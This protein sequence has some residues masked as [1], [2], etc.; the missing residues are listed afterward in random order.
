MTAFML[1]EMAEGRLAADALLEMQRTEAGRAEKLKAAP[2]VL[3][4]SLLGPYVLG[5]SFLLRGNLAGFLEKVPAADLDRAFRQPPASTEQVLHPEKYWGPGPADLPLP[6]PLPD[7]SPELGG[8]WERLGQGA[9]GEMIVALLTGSTAI[10]P[11]SFDAAL[12]TK[13]TNEGASG[14]GGDRWVLYGRGPQR[15]LILGTIWDT[16]R[17]AT[18]FAAALKLPAGAKVER[19]GAAVALVLGE[20]SGRGEKLLGAALAAIAPAPSVARGGE[21]SLPERRPGSD[22]LEAAR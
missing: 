4:R 13:W 8:G 11:T 16:E 22:G 18:E 3:Q 10:D 1:R 19:R 2:P 17:D 9:L 6:V 20:T 15:I 7:F 5:A 21:L 12:A 14:W